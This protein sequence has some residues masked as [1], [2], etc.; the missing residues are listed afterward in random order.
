MKV[1][2]SVKAG[3]VLLLL[4]VQSVAG[5]AQTTGSTRLPTLVSVVAPAYPRLANDAP[6]TGTIVTHIGCAC[7]WI[8]SCERGLT[9]G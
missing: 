7:G 8:G 5:H 6:M 9:T 1:L 4:A 2:P 3:M